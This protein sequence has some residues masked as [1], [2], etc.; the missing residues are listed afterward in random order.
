MAGHKKVYEF[1]QVREVKRIIASGFTD[2][3]VNGKE[4]IMVAKHLKAS[5]GYGAIRLEK[6]LIKFCLEHDHS[7]NPVVEAENIGMWIRTAMRVDNPLREIKNVLIKHSEIKE[8]KKIKDPKM[9]KVLYSALVLAK[10]FY[11]GGDKY[12]L[13]I[14]YFLNGG[15][16]AV[17]DN[18]KFSFST[19]II[20]RSIKFLFIDR[21]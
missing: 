17:T 11:K 15:I 20:Y 2:V 14:L 12:Y 16:V 3:E 6:A 1:N 19:E 21:L 5:T 13:N 7:F 18:R 10:S 4:A 9:R 8:I